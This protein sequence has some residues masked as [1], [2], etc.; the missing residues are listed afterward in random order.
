M[1][2]IA[3]ASEYT[4]AFYG[5]EVLKKRAKEVGN[6]DQSVIDLI[7]SMF[8]VMHRRGALAWLRLRLPF[9]RELSS[10]TSACTGARL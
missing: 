9:R 2:K 1:N 6:I 4:L 7:E 10:L 3:K 5:N 8:E